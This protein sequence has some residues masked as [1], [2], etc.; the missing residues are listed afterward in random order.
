M[1]WQRNA[2]G[3]I[4]VTNASGRVLLDTL[5]IGAIPF[6]VWIIVC[7]S[8]ANPNNR[9][10]SILNATINTNFDDLNDTPAKVVKYL[11]EQYGCEMRYLK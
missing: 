8:I 4:T 2:S 9:E 3:V 5:V 1:A 11:Q 6:G 7:E 10:F